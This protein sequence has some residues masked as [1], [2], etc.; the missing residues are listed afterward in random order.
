MLDSQ[1]ALGLVAP[2]LTLRDLF[3]VRRV[4]RKCCE[5][6]PHQTWHMAA[7]EISEE[8]TVVRAAK[9]F[10]NIRH[11]RLHLVTIQ[12]SSLEHGFRAWTQ[13]QLSTL[14]LSQI[15]NLTD[16]HLR[17][18]TEN[19]PLLE[20]LAV[21]QCYLLKTPTIVGPKLK[22]LS[23]ENCLIT[24]F[25]DDTIWPDLEELHVSSRVLATLEA[26]HLLKTLLARSQIQ[27]LDLADCFMIEQI[28]IDPSDLPGLRTLNLRS[29][30]GLKRVH[31]ASGTVES[32]DLSL[33]VEL[34][35]A[36]LHLNQIRYLDLSYL[37]QLT[38]LHLGAKSIGLLN[39]RACSQ[40]V[41]ANLVVTCPYITMTQL[42]G[43]PLSLEDLR[44]ADVEMQ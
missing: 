13:W 19:C 26:R 31:L 38:S 43:T 37:Q 16:A 34:E 28:L 15:W 30:L 33:C 17:L 42:E 23:M 8:T 20:R 12:A 35:V 21:R 4:S 6:L 3:S 1:P 11:A 10:P 39:L 7:E 14:E 9:A 29:C 40:L 44:G 22:Y 5:L 41:R 27:V 18:V 25:Q 36:I 24:K 2:W 32:I